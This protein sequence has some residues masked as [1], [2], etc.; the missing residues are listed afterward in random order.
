[1]GLLTFI[2][3][4]IGANILLGLA[5]A[6][7]GGMGALNSRLP[8]PLSYRQQLRLGQSITLGAVLLPILGLICGSRLE[9]AS[10]AQVWSAYTMQT[11]A[12]L[13]SDEFLSGVIAIPSGES[14]S[15][16]H[17]VQ[18][19]GLVFFTGVLCVVLRVVTDLLVTRR[20]LASAYRIRR[21]G[22]L[23]ILASDRVAVPF[24]LWLPARSIVV[25]PTALL[26]EWKDLRVVLRHEVQHHRQQDTTLLYLQAAFKAAFFWNPAMHWLDS[27]LRALQELACD[28]ALRRSG[29]FGCRDY[30][31]CLLRMAQ[32]AV[33]RRSP[34][35]A[36]GM[37]GQATQ[38]LLRRRIEAVLKPIKPPSGK[39]VL[40]G[41]CSVVF[42]FMAVT[43][44]VFSNAIQDRRISTNTAIRMVGNARQGAEFPIT[45]NERV[46][47]QLNL[48]LATP[49]GRAYLQ[50]RLRRMEVSAPRLT[51][52]LA[53][54]HLPSELVAIPLVESG[55]QNLPQGIDPNQGAGLWMIIEPTAN[56]L[57]LKV[58]ANH[59]DR[60]DESVETDA[61][62]SFLAQL[63]RQFNDW[64]LA[65]LGYNI[66]EARVENGI[67]ET[68]SRD[69]WTLI[70][71][72]YENDQDY[73]ARVM[74]AILVIKNPAALN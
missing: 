14:L 36:A 64:G 69:A 2:N 17:A 42:A 53:R 49:D 27:R 31:E 70:D 7:L 28:E 43:A 26:S 45:M 60:L 4:L 37:T 71:D 22:R 5:A 50:N 57:G 23:H 65:L 32:A 40:T 10:T 34:L 55:Y 20:I 33:S 61:A 39:A 56:R 13:N 62:L 3:L 19:A 30:C 9:P 59:D 52:Q 47:R 15:L 58:N 24:S 54:H 46:L 1:M 8:Q 11:R 21:Q 74:A 67:R 35:L 38:S 51:A 68:G 63:H 72:G 73:L 66:G 6:M 12:P 41:I 29:R 16:E 48:W 18:V 44:L 25:V